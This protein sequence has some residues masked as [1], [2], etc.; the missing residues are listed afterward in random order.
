[1]EEN[2]TQLTN[3]PSHFFIVECDTTQVSES[4]TDQI[5]FNTNSSKQEEVLESVIQSKTEEHD[6]SHEHR[7][8]DLQKN[9]R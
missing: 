3:L 5:D 8:E 7:R 9:V 1:M 4:A 2:H 6:H